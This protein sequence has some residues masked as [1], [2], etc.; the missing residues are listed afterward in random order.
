MELADMLGSTLFA[1]PAYQIY[2]RAVAQQRYLQAGFTV[3]LGVERYR[4]GIED[5]G[6]QRDTASVRQPAA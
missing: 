1:C 2:G 5:S 4:S 3:T 6:G